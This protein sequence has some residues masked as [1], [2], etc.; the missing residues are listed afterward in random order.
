[1]LEPASSRYRK[2]AR[3]Y[4]VRRLQFRNRRLPRAVTN[5]LV[6]NLGGQMRDRDS[7]NLDGLVVYDLPFGTSQGFHNACSCST[8]Y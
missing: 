1:M 2:L 5:P 7:Q 6:T 3:Q 8:V 4:Y